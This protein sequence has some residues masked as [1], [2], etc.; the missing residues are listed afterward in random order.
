MEYLEI[1]FNIDLN[2]LLYSMIY[3][4]QIKIKIIKRKPKV[5]I[6]LFSVWR[7]IVYIWK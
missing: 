7:K 1:E 6:Y 5:N 3:P 2:V 4:Q